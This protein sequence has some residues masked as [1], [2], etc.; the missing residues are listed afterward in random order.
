[1][2]E[3]VRDR[4]LLAETVLLYM[5]NTQRQSYSLFMVT[6]IYAIDNN[7]VFDLSWKY[8]NQ[9][10]N[11]LQISWES[12]TLG[13]WFTD[14][15]DRNA[16]FHSWLFDGRP[17]SFWMTGFFNPQVSHN[18]RRFSNIINQSSILENN[19]MK[20]FLI[21]LRLKG[22]NH[23]CKGIIIWTFLGLQNV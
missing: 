13:F 10:F 22:H 8:L 16:Q 11:C 3:I 7:L 14:L 20:L 9:L 19:T 18:N 6:G 2:S 1:M 5:Y 21:R 4:S 12:A 17:H 23:G 15:L